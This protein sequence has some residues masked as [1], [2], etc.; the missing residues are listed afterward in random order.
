MVNRRPRETRSQRAG[1]FFS[2]RGCRGDR[3]GE[4]DT[5]LRGRIH[6]GRPSVGV[7]NFCGHF[8]TRATGSFF[9]RREVV[10]RARHLPSSG[11]R[12]EPR[13]WVFALSDDSP[14]PTS[15]VASMHVRTSRS[16]RLGLMQAGAD[17]LTSARVLIRDRGVSGWCSS[18]AISDQAV[19]RES[20]PTSKR[21]RTVNATTNRVVGLRCRR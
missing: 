2:R 12:P 6:S 3:S 14:Y 17:G 15:T 11:R 7:A 19:S 9:V 8:A 4:R 16:S 21:P 1:R 10:G 20:S 5:S 13:V 18:S